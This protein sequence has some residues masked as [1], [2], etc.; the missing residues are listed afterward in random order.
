[1]IVL[2]DLRCAGCSRI[3]IS[4]SQ[5]ATLDSE[6]SGGNSRACGIALDRDENAS[7]NL[8]HLGLKFLGGELPEGLREVT[9]VE[10]T[11]L[12]PGP[13]RGET[14]LVEAGSVQRAALAANYAEAGRK[15]SGAVDLGLPGPLTATPPR[16]RV[17]R[18]IL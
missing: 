6:S 8:R 15:L 13:T 5:S 7:I 12:A 3:G 11:A 17:Q 2:E 4:P 18:G 16:S 14:S 10:R 1:V 9:P